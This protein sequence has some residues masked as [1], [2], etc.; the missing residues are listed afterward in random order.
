MVNCCQEAET[1][2]FGGASPT[3]PLLSMKLKELQDDGVFLYMS[4]VFVGADKQGYKERERD[5]ARD[6]DRRLGSADKTG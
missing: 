4:T 2:M 3:R 5:R 1:Y 6:R